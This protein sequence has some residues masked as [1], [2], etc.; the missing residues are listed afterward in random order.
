MGAVVA[1]TRWRDQRVLR[2]IHLMLAADYRGMSARLDEARLARALARPRDVVQH[3]DGDVVRLAAS[4]AVS[5]TRSRSVTSGNAAL[6]LAALS[7]VLRMGG[8]RLE[9]AE[10]EAAAVMRALE[11]GKIGAADFEAWTRENAASA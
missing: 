5:V 10:A 8:M 2:A 4:Y 9:C 6:G 1:R 3:G 7:T 11:T